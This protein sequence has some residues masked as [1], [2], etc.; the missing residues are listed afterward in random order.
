MRVQETEEEKQETESDKD[1]NENKKEIREKNK[2]NLW[3]QIREGYA[4]SLP[5]LGL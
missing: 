2:T 1:K 5:F 4:V 3:H